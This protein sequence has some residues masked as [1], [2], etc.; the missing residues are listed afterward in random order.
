[1]ARPRTFDPGDVLDTAR[2]IFWRKGFQATSLDDITAETGLTKTSLYAA[3]GDKAAL[4]LKVLD[5]YHDQIVAKSRPALTGGASAREA[6]EAWLFSFVPYCSGERG[7]RGCLSVNTSTDGGL[8]EAELRKSIA[9]FNA[10]LEDL[11]VARLE[12]DRA[13][14]SGEFNPRAAA[15]AILAV[16]FGL[17]VHAK[18]K[19]AP[20]PVRAVIKQAMHLLD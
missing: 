20:E 5:R 14:Y 8:D 16:Y 1:M 11:I 7:R 17:M 6:I 2:D 3:F 15:Q 9:R 12:T 10:R 4:F 18:Q 19:P 13:Q